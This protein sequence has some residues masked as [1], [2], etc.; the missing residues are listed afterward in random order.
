MLLL[1]FGNISIITVFIKSVILK[2]GYFVQKT[3]KF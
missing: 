1:L 3:K 2:F